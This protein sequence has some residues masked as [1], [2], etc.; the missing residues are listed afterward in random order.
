MLYLLLCSS[1]TVGLCAAAAGCGGTRLAS[2]RAL[3]IVRP[4]AATN[5]Q[6][7]AGPMT[8]VGER[9]PVEA[10][11]IAGRFARDSKMLVMAEQRERL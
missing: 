1:S 11:M 3:L 6:R 4:Y 9:A 8:G 10:L 5:C 2:A 7:L